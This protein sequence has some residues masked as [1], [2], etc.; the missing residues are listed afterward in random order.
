MVK[1]PGRLKARAQELWGEALPRSLPY[2]QKHFPQ[3]LWLGDPNQRKIA[4]TFDDGPHPQDTPQVLRVLERYQ[5]QATF[6]MVGRE[7]KPLAPLV[8]AVAEAG[9]GLGLHGYRHRPFDLYP[10]VI[11]RRHLLI[12]R[13]LISRACRYQVIGVRDVRPPFGVISPPLLERL[14]RWRFRPVI[15]SLV[16]VHW[17]QP[18]AQTV[19]EVQR[20]VRPGAL[21]VL[22][23]GQHGPAVAEI[24]EKLVPW[25]QAQGYEFITI[26]RMWRM[27]SDWL[28]YRT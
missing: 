14:I 18:L 12:T 20:H 19:S 2:L 16:P 9:H 26:D 17:R 25:L 28:G 4:L 6:F 13:R 5:V 22:H 10:A 21:I 3:V 23:E 24:L 11:V 15:G 27:Q 1:E 7:V 8:R